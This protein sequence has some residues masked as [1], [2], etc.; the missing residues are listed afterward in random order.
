MKCTKWTDG[1]HNFVMV[2]YRRILTFWIKRYKNICCSCGY[3]QEAGS[4]QT[5]KEEGV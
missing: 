5:E 1:R 4:P 3:E 2:Y